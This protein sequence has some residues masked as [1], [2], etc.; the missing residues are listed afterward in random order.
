MDEI[1][2]TRR[3]VF[4]PWVTRSQ[5]GVEIGPGFRPTFPKAEGWSILTMD[6]CDTHDLIA[7]FRDDP[8]VPPVLLDQIESVDLVWA[9]G[10]Y[11]DVPG[12]PRNLDFVVAC[13]VIEHALDFIGFLCGMSAVLRTDGLLLLAVPSAHLCF[14]FYRPVSTLGDVLMAHRAPSVYDVKARVDQLYLGSALGGAICWDESSLRR[15]AEEGEGPVPSAPESD[16]TALVR[17]MAESALEDGQYRDG[18]RWVFE[19]ET[20]RDLVY[21]LREAGLIDLGIETIV[22]GAGCEFL[23]VLRRGAPPEDVANPSRDGHLAWAASGPRL[24]VDKAIQLQA[25]ELMTARIEL[26]TA[27]LAAMESSTSWRLTLPLRWI[28]NSLAARRA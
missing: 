24:Q 1:Q 12:M 8:N 6:H 20:F 3:S 18:H 9:G 17:S 28:K 22:P 15:A 14:D 19:L 16:V 25:V 5:R 10:E 11:S 26:M 27:R 7:K 23:V 2:V 4:E 13:H 21:R